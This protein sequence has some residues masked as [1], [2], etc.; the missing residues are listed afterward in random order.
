MG[1]R[2]PAVVLVGNKYPHGNTLTPRDA[3][4]GRNVKDS[5]AVGRYPANAYGLYDMAGNVWE[6][7]LDEYDSDFYFT[8][9]RSGVAR[10]PL[11]GANSVK[12]LLDNFTNVKLS[13]V[14]RGGSWGNAAQ[15]RAG[16]RSR[17][18]YANATRSTTS[19]FVVRGPRNHLI[20]F[21]YLPLVSPICAADWRSPPKLAYTYLKI[22]NFNCSI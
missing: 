7:C 16:R 3:N 10:N 22:T 21:T 1:T 6:W 18:Q 13:R 9:P 8:F 20:Y 19:V 2:C 15:E 17:Q 14:L 4:Y 11:S 12:W 5:T